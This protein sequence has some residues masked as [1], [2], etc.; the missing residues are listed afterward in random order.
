MQGPSKL[1]FAW[2]LFLAFS[3]C[4]RH[5]LE[6]GSKRSKQITNSYGNLKFGKCKFWKG[7][8]NAI[9]LGPRGPSVLFVDV[10]AGAVGEEKAERSRY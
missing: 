1:S 5:V 7:S 10:A 8:R 3:Q 6:F 9:L 4:F 2:T